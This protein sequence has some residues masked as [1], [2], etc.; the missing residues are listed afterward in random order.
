M[1]PLTCI[2]PIVVALSLAGCASGNVRSANSYSAPAP[3][4]VA[5]PFYDPYASYGEANAT[6]RPPV[7]DRAGTIV[8][9]VEPSVH[10][11][12]ADYEHAPWATGASGGD[13]LAPVGTF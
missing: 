8:K 7:V 11:A 6:W 2:T 3:P 9:P 12:R 13:R 4:P 5:H 10:G 1:R